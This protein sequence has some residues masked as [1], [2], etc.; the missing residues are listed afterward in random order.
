MCNWPVLQLQSAEVSRTVTSSFVW[1]WTFSANVNGGIQD[2]DN[3]TQYSSFVSAL[4]TVYAKYTPTHLTW[5]LLRVCAACPITRL[6]PKFELRPSWNNIHDKFPTGTAQV[7]TPDSV[8]MSRHYVSENSLSVCLSF[9]NLLVVQQSEHG[10]ESGQLTPF[11]F[12]A[13]PTILSLDTRTSSWYSSV[14]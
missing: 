14:V 11:W 12:A 3:W 13:P 4:F 7:R 5:G 2:P 9:C 6:N 1:R 10:T 8:C